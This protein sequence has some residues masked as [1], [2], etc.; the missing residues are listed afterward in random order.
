[1]RFSAVKAA[2][3]EAKR[4]GYLQCLQIK[5]H[6]RGKP[7]FKAAWGP[8]FKVFDVASL[9]K[10]LATTPLVMK[11]VV[12]KRININDKISDHLPF[13]MNRP[14]GKKTIKEFLTHTSGLVAWRPF[15]KD[16]SQ[17]S[18]ENRQAALRSLVAKER[19][20]G[21][22]AVYCDIGFFIL[23]WLIE[24][25]L[26]MPLDEAFDMFI[27]KP[28]KL[29]QTCFGPIP[30]SLCAP[31]AIT[32]LRGRIQGVVDDDNC[33]AVQGVAGHAGLFS[34]LDDVTKM[35]Q[36]FLDSYKKSQVM[37][38]FASRAIPPGKGDWALGFTIPSR[39][40][41]SAGRLVSTQAFGHTGFTGTSL[42][43]DVKRDAVVTILSNRTFPDRKDIR[44]RE[45][46]KR[47]HDHI[48]EA[49]DAG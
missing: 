38:K 46:R 42:W 3:V 43:I 31:T 16:L 39:P 41:S 34:T 18:L 10:I 21:S 45:L 26:R 20:S 48:W 44:F 5:V 36:V 8:K 40:E 37:K 22:Q 47:L 7:V 14:V 28:R 30:K 32:K 1:M 11:L 29:R 6:V 19:L 33:W 49:I 17:V 9:T 27:A 15:F 13:L 24:E 35:G 2:A 4:Q 12:E 23:G 25:K